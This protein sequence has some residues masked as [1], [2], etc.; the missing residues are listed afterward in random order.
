MKRHFYLSKLIMFLSLTLIPI[1]IFGLISVFYINTQVKKNAIENSAST[2]KLIEQNMKELSETLEFYQVAINSDTRIH[3]DLITTLGNTKSNHQNTTIFNQTLQNLYY[4]QCTKPYIQSMFLTIEGSPYFIN[5]LTCEKFENSVDHTWIS[6]AQNND[7]STFFKVRHVK[8]NKFD[9]VTMPVVT[10]YHKIKYQE[11]LAINLRQDYFNQWLDSITNYNGQI[12]LI[13]DKDGQLLFHNSNAYFPTSDPALL[14]SNPSIEDDYFITSGNTY[15]FSYLSLI[16]QTEVFQLSKSLLLLTLIASIAS[17]AVSSVLAYIYTARDYNQINQII[18]LFQKAEK[19]EFEPQK[20]KHCKNNAYFHIINN[21]IQLFMSQTYLK[22]QLDA[23][24]YALSTAQLSALQYQ[25]NPHFLFNT[26]QSI[27]LEILKATHK[28]GQ[29]NLMIQALS[30]LLRYSLETPMKPVTVKEEI[31]V[32]KSYIQLQT[33]RLGEE[34]K[35]IWDYEEEVMNQT[36]IRLLLQPI[37]ENSI[38]HSRLISGQLKIKIRIRYHQE[39]SF[40]IIDN[41]SGIEPA[42]LELLKK[43][44]ND[45]QIEDENHHIGLKNISQRLRLA[46]KNGNLSIYS[47]PGMGTIVT[48]NGINSH[49]K[50]F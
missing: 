38:S 19:G 35:V 9:T 12:L 7:A 2:T 46:Y 11:L 24:K 25:L 29:A 30:E 48:I 5:G 28:P 14:L 41:G 15:G 50:H 37:I 31:F 8:R 16:P 23:K 27:D 47:K 18:T 49:L 36:M 13:S 10:V 20:A 4:S 33:C 43:E 21:I 6:D 34:F 45:N 26:L 22:I 40:T 44:L 17:I 42:K 3:L 1:G 39:L 32:T